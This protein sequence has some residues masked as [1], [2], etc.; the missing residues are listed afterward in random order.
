MDLDCEGWQR[1]NEIYPDMDFTKE[2]EDPEMRNFIRDAINKHSLGLESPLDGPN[3]PVI[4][5]DFSKF[6]LMNGLPKIDEEKCKK[7]LVPKLIKLFGS[8]EGIKYAITEE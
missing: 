2:F 1:I 4:D 8:L 7:K 6:I 3:V 5:D